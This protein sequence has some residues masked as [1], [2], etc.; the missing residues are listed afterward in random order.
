MSALVQI[1]N[2]DTPFAILPAD[3]ANA[4]PYKV[5]KYLSEMKKKLQAIA[6]Q[7]AT[8]AANAKAQARAEAIKNSKDEAKKVFD[9][10]MGDKKS[11]YTKAEDA[12]KKVR[13]NL[14]DKLNSIGAGKLNKGEVKDVYG[15]YIKKLSTE[16]SRREAAAAK[17][18]R[19][20]ELRKQR[21]AAA[22]ANAQNKKEEKKKPTTKDKLKDKL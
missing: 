2:K 19:E 11:D 3:E 12:L 4:K 20:E 16:H 14:V 6:A 10:Y 22:N 1:Y 15:N 18:A 9:D 17:A 21:E 7:N 13:D 8:D 5:K